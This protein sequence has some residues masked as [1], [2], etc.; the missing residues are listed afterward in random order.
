MFE[1]VEQE[2]FL[3]SAQK[4]GERD[5]DRLSIARPHTKRLGNGI[6]HAGPALNRRQ[7]DKDNAIGKV[8]LNLQRD[9]LR[10]SRF[11]NP[12]RAGQGDQRSIAGE[13]Y[14]AS[15]ANFVV[16]AK[17]AGERSRNARPDPVG[18]AGCRLL[19]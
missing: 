4:R 17:N 13:Q 1:V 6:E 9:L 8:R 10:K 14:L 2:E 18:T 7:V 3:L 15:G 11:A 19:E 12:A 5:R 16:A